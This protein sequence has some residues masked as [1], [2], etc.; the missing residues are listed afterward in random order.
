MATY[1]GN[2]ASSMGIDNFIGAIRDLLRPNLF[3]VE[4]ATYGSGGAGSGSFAPNNFK[5]HCHSASVPGSNI[6]STSVD[7]M[8]RGIQIADTRGNMGSWSVTV[9]NDIEF[10]MRRFFEEW[11]AGINA[12]ERNIGYNRIRDYYADADVLQLDQ[13]G[14]V[15]ANYSLKGIFPTS[16][17]QVQLGWGNNGVESFNVDF[18]IGTYWDNSAADVL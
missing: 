8:G 10:A 5:F 15:I 1:Y 3:V 17:G 14:N 9:Y 13:K 2:Q 4:L 12:H 6:S 7:F 18:A 16:V 11:M